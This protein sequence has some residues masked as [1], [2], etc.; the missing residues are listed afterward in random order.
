[1]TKLKSKDTIYFN[2]ADDVKNH[3]N[4][5]CFIVVGGRGTGKTYG[6]L[7]D[8]MHTKRKFVFVKR[9]IED[10]NMMCGR[11]RMT[12]YE[13][14]LSP[15]A[16]INRDY[17]TDVRAI[18]ITKGLCGFWTHVND[19]PKEMIGYVVALNAV[20]K[21]KGF[22]MSVCDWIIFDEFIP[23]PWDRVNRKEG[24]QVLDLYKTVARDREQRGQEPLK[25]V[26]LANA[27]GII[28]PVFQIFEI[29]DD[30]TRMQFEGVEYLERN[31]V[32]VHLL[33]TSNAFMD[34]EKKSVVYGT[35][36][37]TDW[38]RMAYDNEF[39]YN[40]FTHVHKAS[41]KGCVPVFKLLYRK[42]YIYGY[43]SDIGWVLTRS[44]STKIEDFFD[45][46]RE[47]EQRRF[48]LAY[49]IDVRDATIDGCVAFETY[50]MYDLIMNYTDIF[51]I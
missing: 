18:P 48:N 10:V 32:L 13:V 22:N 33:K 16:P 19:K 24:E 31:G 35:L 40:D 5:W 8:C 47:T 6:A 46:S 30:V 11:G 25:L 17:G 20:S 41:I 14:N 34:T 43:K 51:K 45:L 15:F 44:K 42:K 28:N 29:T 12:E 3:P 9:T 4:S 39:A 27:V 7:Y 23:Q 37:D 49:R 2:V 21:I 36:H 38:G 26:C 50:T 1:M